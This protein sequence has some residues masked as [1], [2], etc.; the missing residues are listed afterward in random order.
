MFKVIHLRMYNNYNYFIFE[1]YVDLHSHAY[2]FTCPHNIIC[3][4]NNFAN[5]IT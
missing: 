4:K 3:T 2:L 1:E 5:Y